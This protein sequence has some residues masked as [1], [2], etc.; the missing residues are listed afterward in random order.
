SLD[1]G[2]EPITA[3]R[4]D[5]T[6]RKHDPRMEHLSTIVDLLNERFGTNLTEADKLLFDQF[7]EDWVADP[8]L[9]AQARSNSLDNFRFGFDKKFEST[10]I[11]RMDLNDEIFRRLMDDPAFADTVRNYY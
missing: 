10:V 3:V 11:G 5:G 4:G 6:G 1:E 2:G 7:E 8:D 9:G